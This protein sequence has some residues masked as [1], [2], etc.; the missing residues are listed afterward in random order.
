[1]YYTICALKCIASYEKKIAKYKCLLH[2]L[3]ESYMRKIEKIGNIYLQV[4][5]QLHVKRSWS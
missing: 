4:H 5:K 1:M 2:L 3:S